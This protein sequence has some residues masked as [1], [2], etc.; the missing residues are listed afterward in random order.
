MEKLSK[1]DG[2]TKLYRDE[3]SQA[4]INTDSESYDLYIKRRESLKAQR[5]EI[6]TLKGEVSDIKNLL[7]RLIEKI[8]G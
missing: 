8:D 4:V 2:H 5:E 3:T 7:T 6:E 1:V